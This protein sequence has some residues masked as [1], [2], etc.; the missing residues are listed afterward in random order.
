MSVH[1]ESELPADAP[2][3]IAGLVGQYVTATSP[4]ITLPILRL[5]RGAPQ[6]AVACSNAAEDHCTVPSLMGLPVTRT[7]VR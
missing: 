6:D 5:L 1:D 2:P 3:D 7:A 4:V